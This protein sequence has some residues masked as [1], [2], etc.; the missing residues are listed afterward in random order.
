VPCAGRGRDGPLHGGTG[1]LRL[2]PRRRARR[3]VRP[4][5]RRPDRLRPLPPYGRMD[6]DLVPAPATVHHVRA[7]G[8]ACLRRVQRLPPRGRGRG[9][10][11]R[12]ALPRSPHR[13]RGLPRRR[14]PRRLPGVCAMRV[15]LLLIAALAAGRAAAA[16]PAAFG[17]RPAPLPPL[18]VSLQSMPHGMGDTR[19]SVCHST[20]GWTKVTFDHDRTGFPL[21]GGHAVTTCSSCHASSDFRAALPTS[22]AACHKD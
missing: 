13:L 8:E 16:G 1:G 6:G 12:P 2:V 3:T 5:P 15:A 14:P 4:W 18:P 17:E 21:R 19:C 10:R 20:E 11:P 7:A 9:G 22:C